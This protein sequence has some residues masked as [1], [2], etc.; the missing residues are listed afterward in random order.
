DKDKQSSDTHK[1]RIITNTFLIF[2]M[3]FVVF[4]AMFTIY[5]QFYKF[6]YSQYFIWTLFFSCLLPYLQSIL[7]GDGKT[8]EFAANGIITS[9]LIVVL[10]ITFI[11]FLKLKVEGILLGNIIA[12]ALASILIIFRLKLYSF[13]RIE[14]FDKELARQMLKYSLP[15]IPNLVSWWLISAASKFIILKDLGIDAYGIYAISSRFPAILIIIN[16]VLTLPI[17]DAYLK[18]TQSD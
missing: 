18:G 4:G 11:Y 12:N 5:L 8:K 9:F 15:L 6:N 10:N 13:L 16:S 3:G 1:A 17:Q 2:I 7:R 14:C